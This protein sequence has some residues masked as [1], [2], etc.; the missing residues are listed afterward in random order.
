MSIKKIPREYN[1]ADML[2]HH[3]TKGEGDKF[4]R[5]VSFRRIEAELASIRGGV[6]EKPSAGSEAFMETEGVVK[7]DLSK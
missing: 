3:Y 4:L 7:R 1:A 2:T 5:M 6:T